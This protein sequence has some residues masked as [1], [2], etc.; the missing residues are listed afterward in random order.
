VAVTGTFRKRKKKGAGK[1]K[2]TSQRKKKAARKQK[3]VEGD[4]LP[5]VKALA[6]RDSSVTMDQLKSMAVA[7]N[8]AT[9]TGLGDGDD[10]TDLIVSKF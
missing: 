4:I 5:I 2:A 7:F 6:R 1:K 8:A 3:K 9:M 10:V